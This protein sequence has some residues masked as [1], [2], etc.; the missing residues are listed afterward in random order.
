MYQVMYHPCDGGL[1]ADW[2]CLMGYRI[3]VWLFRL[4]LCKGQRQGPRT[5]GVLPL[6]W[7]QQRDVLPTI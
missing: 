3:S 2:F 4:L 6:S 5:A 7:D 1:L